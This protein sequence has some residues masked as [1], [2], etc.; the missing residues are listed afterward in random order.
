MNNMAEWIVEVHL[1]PGVFRVKVW[2]DSQGMAEAAARLMFGMAGEGAV[3]W[4]E[5]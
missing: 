3:I 2:A 5:A 1:L 4:R